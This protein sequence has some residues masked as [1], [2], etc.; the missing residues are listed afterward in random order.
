M[1][2]KITP[3]LIVLLVVAAFLIGSMWTKIRTMEKG[4]AIGQGQVAVNSPIPTGSVAGVGAGQKVNVIISP[5]D[6]IKGN[7]QAKVTIIEFSDF[8]CPYCGRVQETMNKILETYGDQVRIVFKNYPLAF[9]ENAENAA[10]AALC[11]KE[12]GKFWEYHDLLFKNQ[13]A[14]SAS[15]LKKYASDLGLKTQ[16]FNS[17]LDSKKYKN[18]ISD[19]MKEAQRIGVEATPSFFVNGSLLKGAQPFENFKLLID[20]ELKK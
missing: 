15:N 17:C 9:H 6:P 18:Q 1:K 16:D 5:N 4:G 11:A 2:N 7:P 20:E 10:L 19:D 13:E 3:I 14:L 12:Q 8:Q